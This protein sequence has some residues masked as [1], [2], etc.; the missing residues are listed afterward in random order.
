MPD[1]LFPELSPYRTHAL[2]VDGL[3]TLNVE[4]YG[5]PD[6]TP[7]VYLHGGPGG[8]ISLVYAR[9]FDPRAY[10]IILFDQ[11]GCGRSTPYGET[12]ANSP[13]HLVV[14]IEHIRLH[15]GLERW[16]IAG[17]SWGSTLALLYGI[18]YPER[19]LS[20]TLRGI[21]LMRGS[22]ID[23]FLYG[24]QQ[25]RPEAHADFTAIIPEDERHD[26][27]AAYL[28]LLEHPDP[29]VHM[30]AGRRWSHY[31]T[32]CSTLLPKVSASA[33][34]T[35]PKDVDSSLSMARLEAHYFARHRFLPDDF[36]LRNVDRLR[37]IP[38]VIVQGQY[39]LICPPTSAWELHQVWP[40]AELQMIPDAGHSLME[41][42]ITAALLAAAERFKAIR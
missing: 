10:R 11:R 34:S 32:V 39:D 19:I 22:E 16:H 35:T 29:T 20:L 25:M 41:S 21:F 14:D 6:G 38:A 27:L 9:L 1:A 8:G 23:W 40:E 42:G 12:S 31:E 13:A 30:E 33:T 18:A 7:V 24:L 3:H 2:P 17:G 4:E 37:N 28:K 5:N 15:L 26:L 36:I